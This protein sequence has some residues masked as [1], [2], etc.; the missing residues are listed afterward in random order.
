MAAN[1]YSP[2]SPLF[3]DQVPISP[4]LR[5]ETPLGLSEHIP[6]QKMTHSPVAPNEDNDKFHGL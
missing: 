4:R 2:Q 1:N 3:N 6:Q 5:I